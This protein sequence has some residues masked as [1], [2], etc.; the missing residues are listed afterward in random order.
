MLIA[1]DTATRSMGIA[2]HDGQV[3]VAEQH[4]ITRSYHTMQLAPEIALMLRRAEKTASSLTAV[5]VAKGPGSYT[6]LRIGMALAKGLALAHNLRMVGIPTLDII[7]FNQPQRDEP[8]LV[9][10][11][12]GRGRVATMWYKW[13]S[14]EWQG[15]S[16]P[17]NL[18]WEEI[19]DNLEEETYICGEINSRGRNLLKEEPLALIAPPAL[20]V[21]RPGVLA[22]L[23]LQKI[24][25]G[26]VDDPSV[27]APIYLPPRSSESPA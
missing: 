4:W 11:E 15:L 7:A 6:G 26:N 13:D 24:R 5:A 16:E 12:A 22:D 20:S 27:L 19:V 23:G 14:T 10:I 2:L 17:E 21:R 8:M 3:I 18:T 1:I 9:I 25:S